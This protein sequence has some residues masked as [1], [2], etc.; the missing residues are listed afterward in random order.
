MY[1]CL[2]RFSLSSLLTMKRELQDTPG[3]CLLSVYVYFGI[4][5]LFTLPI[6]N[7]VIVVNNKFFVTL[8]WEAVNAS[9]ILPSMELENPTFN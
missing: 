8:F 2:S 3:L 5:L 7:D 6:T 1:Y 4:V 9:W